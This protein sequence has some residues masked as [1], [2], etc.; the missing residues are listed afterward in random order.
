MKAVLFCKNPYAFGILLPLYETLLNEGHNTIWYI[1]QSL[2]EKCP[3]KIKK[4]NI[5]NSMQALLQFNGDA[6]FV[7]GNIIP[8]YLPGVKVQVFHG[9]AG[10]KKGHFRIRHYFDLYLTQGP[11]FTERFEELAA[12]H[13]NFEVAETGWCK[14]D[15]LYRKETEVEKAD[16]GPQKVLYAPTFSPSLTSAEKYMSPLKSLCAN[17]NIELHVKFHD[18]MNKQIVA[19]Y[20]KL[21]S[22]HD[23]MIISEEANILPL[24]KQCDLMISDTSSVVYEFLLLDKPVITLETSSKHIRWD[25]LNDSDDLLAM[26][27][28]NLEEDPYKN[29]RQWFIDNYHPYNDEHSSSRM[30][31]AVENY[32]DKHG[33]PRHRQL[34]FW[35][36]RKVHKTFGKKPKA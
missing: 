15:I 11:Y 32:I 33:V 36:R 23:N 3:E 12:K 4:A 27:T 5:R 28:K 7:P 35:R 8:H 18:L 34:S 20:K 14:L 31:K 9:F 22:Q 25:N 30:I 19:Q 21:A 6:N 17:R 1:P 29:D 16:N 24:M 13:K 2:M 26:V 10:E